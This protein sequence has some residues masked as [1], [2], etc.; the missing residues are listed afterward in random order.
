M[1]FINK[2]KADRLVQLNIAPAFFG[3]VIDS[4]QSDTII[5]LSR[6]Y[7]RDPKSSTLFD[8]LQFMRGAN[9][10]IFTPESLQSRDP[11]GLKFLE[12]KEGRLIQKW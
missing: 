10:E 7:D 9:L 12:T 3:L 8:L 1:L 5:S 2:R 4:L 6:I 11:N